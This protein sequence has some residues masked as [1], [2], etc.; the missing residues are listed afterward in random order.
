AGIEDLIAPLDRPE[1]IAMPHDRRIFA[2]PERLPLLEKVGHAVRA[3]V[4]EFVQRIAPHPRRVDLEQPADRRL[5][6]ANGRVHTVRAG[7]NRRASNARRL[8]GNRGDE[9]R[10]DRERKSR[11]YETTSLHHK[12][13]SEKLYVLPGSPVNDGTLRRL[14]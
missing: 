10:A 6:R 1:G 12:P 14:S 4:T 7:R 5:N 3:G 8:D 9:E 2:G 11:R 13:P